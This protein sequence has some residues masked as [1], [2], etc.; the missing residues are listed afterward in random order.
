MFKIGGDLGAFTED[1]KKKD[2]QSAGKKIYDYGQGIS[3]GGGSVIANAAMGGGIV[4]TLT[5]KD[6]PATM[7][8]AAPNFA[9]S[10]Q[11]GILRGEKRQAQL[12]DELKNVKSRGG[13]QNADQDDFINQLQASSRGE[14]PSAAQA[15]LQQATDQNMRQALAMAASSRG[16]PAL[17]M[18]AAG[19][20]RALASQQGA[21]QSA[22]LR[23]R[24][25]Q[26]AQGMLGS[27]IQGRNQ[28]VL[29]Q[30]AQNDMM[31]QFY[32]QGI[33]GQTNNLNN[34][35]MGYDQ[36]A[37]GNYQAEMNRAAARDAARSQANAAEKSGLLS[38][39]GTIGT[40]AIM[41]SDERMKK[42][43]S[44]VAPEHLDEF[45]NA[46]QPKSFS[47]KNANEVGASKGEKV[48]MMA[49]DVDGTELGKKLFQTDS[50]GM[51]KYDPQVLDGILLAAVQKVMKGNKNG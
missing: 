37:S 23:A 25:I 32:E 45:F 29:S 42:D 36:L 50:D 7:V 13:F 30:Q 48:G 24:E 49:Q 11:T 21:A 4:D 47:Y 8:G 26:N 40:A 35:G 17:A 3:T 20:Q 33:S 12:E 15:Q 51:K 5:K 9:D 44:K 19:R 10:R 1:I 14:G 34:L 6:E 18:Q 27:A 39:A 2:Y 46:L 31:Q 28:N 41:A 22:D 43:V 16:N 38:A